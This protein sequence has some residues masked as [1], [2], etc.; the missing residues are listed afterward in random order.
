MI[1]FLTGLQGIPIEFMKQQNLMAP[2]VG[3]SRCYI[4]LPLLRRTINFAV[5]T[6]TIFSFTVFASIYVMTKGGPM[7][8]T[9]VVIYQIYEQ[10]FR[11]NEVG[12]ASAQAVILMVLMAAVALIQARVL[13]PKW[14]INLIFPFKQG[15]L[16]TGERSNDTW[17]TFAINI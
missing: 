8:S 15:F 10:A 12:Y 5:I 16:N 14:S 11:L 17:T 3:N 6:S 4:T 1:I 2:A 7:N 13:R 9:R